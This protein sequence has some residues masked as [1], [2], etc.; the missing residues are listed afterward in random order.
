MHDPLPASGDRRLRQQP[1]PS[2]LDRF[3]STAQRFAA[4]RLESF[5]WEVAFVRRPMFDSPTVV[6]SDAMHRHYAILDEDGD[7]Q[8]DPPID[9]RHA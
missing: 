9:I 1:V 3:L 5:G 2:D 6:L 4:S 8:V 7:L